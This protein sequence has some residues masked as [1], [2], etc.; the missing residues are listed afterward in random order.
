MARGSQMERGYA[1]LERALRSS[2]ESASG[3]RSMSHLLCSMGRFGEAKAAARRAVAI[4]PDDPANHMELSRTL[5]EQRDLPGAEAAA[6]RAIAL[7]PAGGD[8]H[9]LLASVLAETERVFDVVVAARRAVTLRPGDEGARMLLRRILA[10]Q[11]HAGAVG[12]AVPQPAMINVEA[13]G[14]RLALAQGLLQCG[15][16]DEALG[17]ARS[18]IA[19]DRRNPHVH[20][21]LGHILACKNDPRAAE[22]A[23]RH[24]VAIDP[25]FT[26]FRA[27]LAH[28]LAAQGKDE[29]AITL[30]REAVA[31]GTGDPRIHALLG[32]LL[33][34]RNDLDGAATA[35][36]SALAMD[37]PPDATLVDE[38]AEE[39]SVV[40]N[41]PTRPH[42]SL[43]LQVFR[44]RVGVATKLRLL[45]TSLLLSLAGAETAWLVAEEALAAVVA[46]RAWPGW[47]IGPQPA[48]PRASAAARNRRWCGPGRPPA[49]PS[50]P[51]PSVALARRDVRAALQRIV[52]RQ[53]LVDELRAGAGQRDHL[54]G[55]LAHRELARDCR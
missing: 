53:R 37:Q 25:D 55:Q 31:A 30:L 5:L 38:L 33:A 47:V 54:L 50:A 27:S 28:A 14:K 43:D 45:I 17:V 13:N 35:F 7:F 6:R 32:R 29:E 46:E 41:G 44:D 8:A 16:Y 10:Q 2:P 9:Q 4:E 3:W 20:A 18:L 51:S 1:L 15:Q 11:G 36:R 23:F 49:A 40:G 21:L 42:P 52:G 12:A 39:S 24:A 22:A 26:A 48:A 19:T 34:R